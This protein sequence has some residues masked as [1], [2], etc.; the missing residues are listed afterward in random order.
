MSLRYSGALFFL[1]AAIALKGVF[2]EKVACFR[3]P[4]KK[5]FIRDIR[6]NLIDGVGDRIVVHINHIVQDAASDKD[7]PDGGSLVLT[8][9]E[10]K[11][12]KARFEN[13]EHAL[14]VLSNR[15]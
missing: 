11:D 15:L 5:D 7:V 12:S 6:I 13:A 10:K 8:H 3:F 9:P 4:S 14:Y 2:W 1:L